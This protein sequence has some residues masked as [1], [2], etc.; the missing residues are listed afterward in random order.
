MGDELLLYLTRPEKSTAREPGL[1][2]VLVCGRSGGLRGVADDLLYLENIAG[3]R[4]KTRI[5]GTIGGW[6]NP[7]LAVE[8]KE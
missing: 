7:D 1:W 6:R 8:G 2:F 5:S 3:R 4:G